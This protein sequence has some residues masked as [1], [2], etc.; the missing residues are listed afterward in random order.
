MQAGGPHATRWEQR[1]GRRTE[2]VGEPSGEVLCAHLSHHSTADGKSSGRRCSPEPASRA[3]QRPRAARRRQAGRVR[4]TVSSRATT[5]SRHECVRWSASAVPIR[6]S[7]AHPCRGHAG[8]SPSRPRR[9]SPAPRSAWRPSRIPDIRDRGRPS[10]RG[11][12]P[13]WTAWSARGA[14]RADGARGYW[15]LSASSSIQEFCVRLTTMSL[16]MPAGRPLML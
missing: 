12:P 1:R 16:C 9:S 13:V 5:G 14:A 4:S 15:T 2:R 6:R 7:N 8:I 10:H 3:P 11:T